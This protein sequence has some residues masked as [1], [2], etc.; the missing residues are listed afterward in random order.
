MPWYHSSW[1][2]CSWSCPCHATTLQTNTNTCTGEVRTVYDDV[3]WEWMNPNDLI[4][5]VNELV[6]LIFCFHFYASIHSLLPLFWTPNTRSDSNQ[7]VIQHSDS[8][9]NFSFLFLN[10]NILFCTGLCQATWPSPTWL[11][12]EL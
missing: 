11:W 12:L 3:S 1:C 4:G 9:L 8:T 10:L 5:I 7:H 2:F 6:V